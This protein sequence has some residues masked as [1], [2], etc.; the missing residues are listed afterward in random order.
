MVKINNIDLLRIPYY[1]MGRIPEILKEK[2][3]L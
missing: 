1:D 3:K 2:L